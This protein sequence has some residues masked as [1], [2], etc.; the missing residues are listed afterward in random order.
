MHTLASV[1]EPMHAIAMYGE[2]ALKPGFQ[3]LPMPIPQAPRAERFAW[4]NGRFGDSLNPWVLMGNPVWPI[5]TQPG[6]VTENADDALA[7]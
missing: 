4:R 2:P 5:F 7:G 1:A 6:L 3:H